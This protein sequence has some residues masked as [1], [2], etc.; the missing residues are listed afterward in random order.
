MMPMVDDTRRSFRSLL[1]V[2]LPA[3]ALAVLLT[4][5]CYLAAGPS[6]GLFVG[7]LFVATLL[8][9]PLVLWRDDG[10]DRV[11][12]AASI[13]DGV[14]LVWLAA[15]LTPETTFAH[16]LAAYVLLAAY[17]AAL[18]GIALALRRARFSDVAAAV[19][20]VTLAFAW[21]TW[22]V[23]LSRGLTPTVARWLV[24]AHPPLTLNG[25]LLH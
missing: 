13:V 4:A 5:A 20:T 18:C 25:L 3:L 15:V 7:G 8:A 19:V 22:P 10:R 6:L 14:A 9:P 11:M 12:I 16:W 21:L 2:I 17:V 24:P 23:W 1:L